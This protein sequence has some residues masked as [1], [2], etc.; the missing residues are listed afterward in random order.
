[1]VA[2][3][4]PKASARLRHTIEGLG[5]YQSLMLLAVPASVVEPLKFA[6]VAIAGSG[7]WIT[8]TVTIVCA[9]AASLFLVERLFRIVRPK[10]LTLPWFARLWSWVTAIRDLALKWFRRVGSACHWYFFLTALIVATLSVNAL[11]SP[12]K[13]TSICNRPPPYIGDVST[14]TG[15]TPFAGSKLFR[16]DDGRRHLSLILLH[17][18]EGGSDPE[19]GWYANLWSKLGY[20]V[21]AYCYFDCDRKSDALPASLKNVETSGVLDAVEWLRRQPFSDGKV[22]VFGFSMGAEMALIV[23]SLDGGQRLPD[24]LIAHS[25]GQFFDPPFN[26]NW[27]KPSCWTCVGQC[28]TTAP[29]APDPNFKWHPSC[30]A[31]TPDT[32]DYAKSGWLTQGKS[33]ASGTRIP[34]EKFGG[35]ILLIQGEDDTA[36]QGRGQTRDIEASLEKS[37][38]SPTTYY[39]PDAGHDFAGTPDMGCEMQL[40]QAYLQKLERP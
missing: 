11:A 34:I 6:A 32:L 39:F 2:R 1:M 4:Q 27:V 12:P 15:S 40:V 9:Y 19:F 20:A 7:H 23:G 26:P 25:P 16:P 24:A 8:G 33:V 29:R 36:W 30:G 18:S 38:K 22:A 31:D 17:G 14:I 21:L 35:P 10:L 3:S 13:G 28:K 37:G 5:P